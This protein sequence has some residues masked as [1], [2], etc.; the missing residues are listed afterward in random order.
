MLDLLVSILIFSLIACLIWF[1]LSQVPMP[2]PMKNIIFA[3]LAV[4][5]V[6]ILLS[7]LPLWPGHYVRVAP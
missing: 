7:Y 2:P 5:F 1:V 4:I 6:I 3:I